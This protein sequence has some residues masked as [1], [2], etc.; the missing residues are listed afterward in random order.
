MAEKAEVKSVIA[1]LVRRIN[2]STRR[3]RALE[4][5][6]DKIEA[7]FSD[8]EGKALVQLGD[9][10]IGLERLGVKISSVSGKIIEL[11]T[12]ISRINKELGKTASKSEMKQIE[13]YLE[14]INPL[15]S[16]FVT[17]EELEKTLEERSAKKA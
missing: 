2:E 11:E 10:K 15:T 3:I 9:L 5:K 7:S 14:I 6:T 8:L 13:T 4:Q 17:Q 16:K 12:G 1:E